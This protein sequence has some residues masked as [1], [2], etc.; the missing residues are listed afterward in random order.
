MFGWGLGIALI[1]DA[2]VIRMIL[3]PSLMRLAGKYNWWHPRILNG[4]YDRFK[5]AD[6]H[7]T[8]RAPAPAAPPAQP[9]YPVGD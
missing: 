8:E 1:L 4:L 6:E 7:E 2:T 5:L 3:V 9:R